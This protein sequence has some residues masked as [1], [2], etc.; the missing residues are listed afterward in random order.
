VG[1]KA[2]KTVNARAMFNTLFDV[3]EVDDGVDGD[4]VELDVDKLD[5]LEA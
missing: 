1:L 3:E 2:R 4:E 5:Q